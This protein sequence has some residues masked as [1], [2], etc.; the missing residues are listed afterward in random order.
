MSTTTATAARG[1]EL[2]FSAE[3]FTGKTFNVD[4]FIADCR[5]RIA[6]ESVLADL[7]IHG[8]RLRGMLLDSAN[9]HF[10]GLS[11]LSAAL[12]RAGNRLAELAPLIDAAGRELD[13]W[14][15]A[16]NA[17]A[18]RL[19]ALE[20]TAADV[21]A[22]REALEELRGALSTLLRLE[23]LLRSG[24]G[25]GELERA[26][27]LSSALAWTL[28]GPVRDT[29]LANALHDR[30]ATAR[31]TLRDR[32]ESALLA[33]LRTHDAELAAAALRSAVAMG[34]ASLSA[35]V[36]RTRIVRP[37]LAREL[38]QETVAGTATVAAA[39]GGGGGEQLS[40]AL[41]SVLRWSE[42]DCA[43]LVAAQRAVGV[44]FGFL[45]AVWSE[46]DE[47]LA[48]AAP[49][50]FS[51]AIP[52]A[53]HSGYRHMAAFLTALEATH[54]AT[55]AELRQFR[56][57]LGGSQ[58][59][60]DKRWNVK[61]YYHLRMQEIVARLETSLSQ[62][63]RQQQ[64]FLRPQQQ[65]PQWTMNASKTLWECLQQCFDAE[66]TFLPPLAAHFVRLALQLVARYARWITDGANCRNMTATTAAAVT[67]TSAEEPWVAMSATEFL[68]PYHD[69]ATLAA[70]V[71][72]AEMRKCVANCASACFPGV[73]DDFTAPVCEALEASAAQ[74]VQAQQDAESVFVSSTAGACCGALKQMYGT[75][76]AVRSAARKPSAPSQPQ[77]SFFVMGVFDPLRTLLDSAATLS[78]SEER[79]GWARR[80]TS[81]VFDKCTEICGELMLTAFR[82]DD[83]M[84]KMASPHVGS[85]STATP[86]ASDTERFLAQLSVDVQELGR[87]ASR[88]GIDVSSSESFQR[89][90]RCVKGSS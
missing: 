84:A 82:T 71:S 2:C 88:F 81:A 41:A 66:T 13:T 30:V 25:G 55:A 62:P 3:A 27:H 83:M 45:A 9:K 56:V 51:P 1:R 59:L 52:D 73:E 60:L 85:T 61:L 20:A 89:L 53:F 86:D 87:S 49:T 69:A 23:T 50:L 37:F 54:C 48:A 40:A 24:G 63:R 74:L 46:T 16:L 72:G 12:A 18:A 43:F 47:A 7:A 4:A 70:L 38:T 11:E 57:R 33:A 17:A 32:L 68:L 36:F 34:E 65:Q 26:A 76:S 21:R 79:L 44:D 64:Q 80:V 19:A 31:A 28:E 78:N 67:T 42:G 10:S 14:L 39:A 29:P 22:R 8:E 6:L 15:D 35:T 75:M 77:P 5:S 90:C 58:T